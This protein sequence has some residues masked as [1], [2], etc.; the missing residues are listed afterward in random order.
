MITYPDLVDK[1]VELHKGPAC[2]PPPFAIAGEWIPSVVDSSSAKVTS[3]QIVLVAVGANYATGAGSLPSKLTAVHRSAP[4][5]VEDKLGRWRKRV[6]DHIIRCA[7]GKTKRHWN[8]LLP[9]DPDKPLLP[10]DPRF[11][12]I[13]NNNFHFVMTN[14][15]PWITFKDW[16]KIR[17]NRIEDIFAILAQPG[18]PNGMLDYFRAL[19][20]I[21]GS[22]DAIWIGH[23]NAEVYGIFSHYRNRKRLDIE[24]WFFD[25]N[26]S[27]RSRFW[28]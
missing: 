1:I 2:A 15:S 25:S 7:S 19:K 6:S 18:I 9:F 4:P 8:G 23:G 27:R 21:V 14:L 13:K 12:S 3:K 20:K 26:L 17:D 5:G 11:T 10:A 22:R 16:A 24:P 28:L